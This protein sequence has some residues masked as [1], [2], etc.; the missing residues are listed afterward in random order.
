[1]TRMINSQ[2]AYGYEYLGN[3]AR[4]VITPLTDRYTYMYTC[5]YWPRTQALSLDTRYVGKV[6]MLQNN[7]LSP[8]L[9][10]SVL[11]LGIY[12]CTCCMSCVG[13]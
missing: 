4:L 1:M 8:I 5:M 11:L 13:W 9:N 2:L 6:G 10:P 7:P 12:I 3:S